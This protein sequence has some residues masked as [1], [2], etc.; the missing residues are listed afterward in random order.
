MKSRWIAVSAL[1]LAAVSLTHA[2]V[3][4]P[5]CPTGPNSGLLLS[6]LLEGGSNQTGC[7]LGD[8]KF[9]N[10]SVEGDGGQSPANVLVVFDQT[11]YV[12]NVTFRPGAAWT[13]PLSVSFKV[14]KTSYGSITDV[15][16]QARFSPVATNDVVAFTV[17]SETKNATNLTVGPQTKQFYCNT[18][19]ANVSFTFTPG[20]GTAGNPGNALYSVSFNFQQALII[21]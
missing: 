17:N 7:T 12:H 1:A 16:A 10:F 2:E 3:V 20:N 11:G 21:G 13:A 14:T 8:K 9:T 6:T 18:Q 19:Y 4:P 5:A 15:I